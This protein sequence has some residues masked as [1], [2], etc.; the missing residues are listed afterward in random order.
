MSSLPFWTRLKERTANEG[1]VAT[2][3]YF[4]ITVLLERV[5]VE[6]NYFFR[7]KLPCR[8]AILKD[9]AIFHSW[10]NLSNHRI[11]YLDSLIGIEGFVKSNLESGQVLALGL[12]DEQPVSWSWLICIKDRYALLRSGDWLI[13]RC[14]T[15][16]AARGLGFFPRSV[17]ALA[18][19]A[20]DKWRSG[21]G[22]AFL[23]ME[24]S[25]ANTASINGIKKA[26][27]KVFALLI[28]ARGR[29]LVKWILSK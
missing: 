18:Q 29:V 16:P 25:I 7:M 28:K 21:Q 22:G 19:V 15:M 12:V 26:G 9:V 11:E 14:M 20:T 10:A 8:G 2:F 4:V 24:C 23:Y 17:S 5:G 3:F 27:M 13:Y 6:V 1:F